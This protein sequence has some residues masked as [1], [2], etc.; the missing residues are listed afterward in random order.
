MIE[1]T[2]NNGE[3]GVTVHSP[4]VLQALRYDA[5]PEHEEMDL[6]QRRMPTPWCW[7]GMES[8]QDS[9]PG[10]PTASSSAAFRQLASLLQQV[11]Q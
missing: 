11:R 6:L 7:E 10:Q 4:S 8:Y 9:E 1:L 5:A 2:E 3:I